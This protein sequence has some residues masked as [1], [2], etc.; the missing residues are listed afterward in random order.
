M[1]KHTLAAVALVLS[2][3]LA[4]APAAVATAPTVSA[5]DET[6]G[7]QDVILA[8]VSG[9]QST[10]TATETR[11]RPRSHTRAGESE[12]LRQEQQKSLGTAFAAQ[13]V[14]AV[15]FSPRDAGIMGMAAI[16]L[17]ASGALTLGAGV[18]RQQRE[19]ERYD[20]L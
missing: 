19:P 6:A 18:I 12:P 2:S 11:S 4:T 7:M 16:I 13:K 14:A 8:V 3:I 20:E 17:A 10:P 9:T 5:Y 1:R 15:P